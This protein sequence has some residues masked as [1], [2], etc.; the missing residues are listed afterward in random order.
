MHS[1][2]GTRQAHDARPG[3][4]LCKACPTTLTS[5]ADAC[6]TSL[7]P[8]CG[9]HCTTQ[10]KG[11]KWRVQGIT[12]HTTNKCRGRGLVTHLHDVHSERCHKKLEIIPDAATRAFE[13]STSRYRLNPCRRLHGLLIDNRVAPLDMIGWLRRQ[14]TQHRARRATNRYQAQHNRQGPSTRPKQ[15][16]KN[17]STSLFEKCETEACTTYRRAQSPQRS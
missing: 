8:A 15:S 11:D 1:I 7:S 12:Q 14:V 2:E 6:T 10:H 4:H 16:T 17:P 3:P 9:T 5:I 13:E